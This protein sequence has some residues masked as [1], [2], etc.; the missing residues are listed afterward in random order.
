MESKTN[1]SKGSL[2]F[3]ERLDEPPIAKKLFGSV[4]W[5]WVWLIVRVNLGYQWL[6]AGIGKIGNPVWTG[7]KAG[8]AISGFVAGALQK[9]TGDHPDVQGWYAWFLENL[10]QPNTKTF[11]FLVAYG[12][13]LVGIALIL[14]LFTGIAAFFGGFMNLNYLLSGTVSTNPILLFLSLVV[15]LA[16]RTAGWWGLDRWALPAL[17]T[18]W[19]PGYV[20]KHSDVP[21]Q[22][23]RETI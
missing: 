14:G 23:A 13:V 6:S 20:F 16:W 8:A 9:T 3:V 11:G 18:P 1:I 10:V 21:I 15:I 12:E 2:A 19:R 7:D 5:S 22:E 17:G 4:K